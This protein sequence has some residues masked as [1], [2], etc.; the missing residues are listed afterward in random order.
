MNSTVY[1]SNVD[2][3]A[4]RARITL[5][6][7]S[8]LS[9]MIRNAFPQKKSAC[10]EKKSWQRAGFIDDLIVFLYMNIIVVSHHGMIW[11]K[12]KCI[13]KLRQFS[14]HKMIMYFS[15]NIKNSIIIFDLAKSDN[16]S[17]AEFTIECYYS[18]SIHAQEPPP[19]IH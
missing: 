14:A 2:Y 13:R 12:I 10:V 8:L 1:Y 18:V 3:E 7:G 4:I 15:C 16:K 11:A 6:S 19:L 17:W 5:K 9:F